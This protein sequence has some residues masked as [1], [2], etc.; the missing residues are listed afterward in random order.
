MKVYIVEYTDWDEHVN[1]GVFSSHEK[2]L[3][4][5]QTLETH[6]KD[7]CDIEEYEVQ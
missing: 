7:R 2:A 3:E 6:E 4:Y 1:Y 5:F